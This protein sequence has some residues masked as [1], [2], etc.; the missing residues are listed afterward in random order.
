MPRARCGTKDWP[1][2][3]GHVGQPSPEPV[4]RTTP[5]VTTMRML[6]TSD[7]TAAGRIQCPAQDD[8]PAR[9]AEASVCVTLETISAARRS[10]APAGPGGDLRHA[11]SAGEVDLDDL[12]PRVQL[13]L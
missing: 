3:R 1:V 2:Q 12:G 11:R 5:P 4:S 9:G 6:T 7:A 8:D 10:K 13:Q